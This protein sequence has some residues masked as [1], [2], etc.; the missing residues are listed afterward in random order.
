K[1]FVSYDGTDYGTNQQDIFSVNFSGELFK[2][3]SERPAGL[4]LGGDYRRESASFQNNP[5]NSGESS[6]NNALST[7]GGYNVKELYGELV[8]PLL[9]GMP[10]V[11]DLELQG[12]ARFNDFSTFGTN[13]TYK[14]GVQ[15]SP[16]RD[17]TARATYGTAFRAPNV[18]E[19]YGGAADDYLSVTDPC[20]GK[21]PTTNA[22]VSQ[23][24]KSGPGA[25]IGSNVPGYTADTSVQFLSKHIANAKLGPEEATTF[26]AGVVLQPQMVRNL[27]VT[28][29]YYNLNVTKAI[30][31]RGAAFIL[32]QCYRAATQDPDMCKLLTRDDAGN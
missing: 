27:S 10:G 28:V 20:G 6:G 22:T 5:I 21:T 25:V 18:G 1:Q 29:D 17:I 30:G 31:T 16:I 3:A 12:A 7:I 32:N 8:I 9:G 26:T 15:Y 19:L 24:C 4:A 23:R 2:L 14:M 13:T 11:E